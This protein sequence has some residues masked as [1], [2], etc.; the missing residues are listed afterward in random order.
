M[1]KSV[2]HLAIIMDGNR[3]WAKER[4]LSSNEG[5]LAG[6]ERLKKLGPEC[7][8]RGITHLTVFAFSTENWKRAEHEVGYLMDLFEKALTIELDEFKRQGFRLKVIGRKEGLRAS[9]QRAIAQAEQDTTNVEKATLTLCVNYGGRAEI[10]DACKQLV[11][12]GIPEDGITEAAI[13]SRMYWPDMPEPD[14]IV[15]TSGE[16]RLSGFLTWEGVYSE[17]YWCRKHWP[18]FDSVELDKALEEFMTRQRRYGG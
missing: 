5:H 18:D 8:A 9:I 10:V 16:E 11:R 12:D 13:T 2:K 3:R 4:G 17:I 1:E 14:L 7:I 6:Y 15:R